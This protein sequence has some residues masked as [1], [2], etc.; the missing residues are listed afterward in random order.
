MKI[1]KLILLFSGNSLSC[2]KDRYDSKYGTGQ[3]TRASW[4][5][6]QPPAA[7]PSRCEA[8]S[9]LDSWSFASDMLECLFTCLVDLKKQM[10]HL[11][12]QQN[13]WVFCLFLFLEYRFFGNSKGIAIWNKLWQT[14]GKSL[15]Q[16]RGACFYR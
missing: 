4:Q 13:G 5:R 14:T 3:S 12:Y 9:L 15:E 11:F 1:T 2:E 8:H 10:S 7:K 6:A 16:G